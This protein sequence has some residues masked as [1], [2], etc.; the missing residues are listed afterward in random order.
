MTQPTINLIHEV[1]GYVSFKDIKDFPVMEQTLKEL[2]NFTESNA[3]MPDKYDCFK[4]VKDDTFEDHGSLV[5][6]KDVLNP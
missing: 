2:L 3:T 6:I 4:F 5:A 1:L